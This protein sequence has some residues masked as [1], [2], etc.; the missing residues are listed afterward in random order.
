MVNGISVATASTP[1]AKRNEC[2]GV[3]IDRLFIT[4]VSVWLSSTKYV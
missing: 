3:K 1:V 2:F 4:F